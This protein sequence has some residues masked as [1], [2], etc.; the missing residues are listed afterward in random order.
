MCCCCFIFTF[1]WVFSVV[2]RFKNGV[3]CKV[4]FSCSFNWMYKQNNV[5]I[6]LDVAALAAVVVYV[7]V[8]MVLWCRRIL[9]YPFL[10]NNFTKFLILFIVLIVSEYKMLHWTLVYIYINI[11]NRTVGN[12]WIS[13]LCYKK[14]ESQF[15]AF[16]FLDCFFKSQ[17]T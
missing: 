10:A 9:F 5:E 16:C 17:I 15:D 13:Y 3:L 7:C 1:H 6:L 14:W 8:C 11:F 12:N 4:F 2:E